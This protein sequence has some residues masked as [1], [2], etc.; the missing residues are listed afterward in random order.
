MLK[1]ATIIMGIAVMIWPSD[2]LPYAIG[3]GL[4]SLASE[5]VQA[6]ERESELQNRLLVLETKI[7][8]VV[9]SGISNVEEQLVR[10]LNREFSLAKIAA[11]ANSTKHMIR[12]LH[13]KLDARGE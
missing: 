6:R 3:V 7:G 11:D 10:R 1:V 8:A 5:R 12:A 13:E 9:S 4:L 2:A